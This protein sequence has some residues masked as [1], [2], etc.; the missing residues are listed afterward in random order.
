MADK[1]STVLAQPV[2]RLGRRLPRKSWRK[3][4][5]RGEVAATQNTPPA[6][7]PYGAVDHSRGDAGTVGQ[8]LA[9]AWAL[10]WRRWANGLWWKNP[11]DH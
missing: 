2:R 8:Y 11:S 4:Y 7:N 6:S 3:A 5:R 1:S 10:G 9:R